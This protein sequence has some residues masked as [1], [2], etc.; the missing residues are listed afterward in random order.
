MEGSLFAG[1]FPMFTHS[2]ATPGDAFGPLGMS[3]DQPRG[4]VEIGFIF[5]DN[6]VK[7]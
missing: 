6:I 3:N 4:V 1:I 5:G 7:K 2:A